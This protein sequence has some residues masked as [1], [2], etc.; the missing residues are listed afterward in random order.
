[1][2]EVNTAL[3]AKK[4]DHEIAVEAVLISLITAAARNTDKTRQDC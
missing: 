4:S 1:M 2:K 3:E